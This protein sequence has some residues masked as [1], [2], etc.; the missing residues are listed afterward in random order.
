MM[1]LIA[2][3]DGS[4]RDEKMSLFALNWK[5]PPEVIR[6]MRNDGRRELIIKK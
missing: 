4:R 2:E 3:G 6:M 5:E 1:Y